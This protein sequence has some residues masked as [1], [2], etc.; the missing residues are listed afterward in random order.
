MEALPPTARGDRCGGGIDLAARDAASRRAWP[1]QA[2]SG[3]FFG[4]AMLDYRLYKDYFPA[5]ALGQ[6]VAGHTGH[7]AP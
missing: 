6:Y 2:Q 1:Q 3:V 4:T 7:A 5:W